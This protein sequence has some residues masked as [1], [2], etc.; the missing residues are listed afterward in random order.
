M[1]LRDAHHAYRDL[2]GR[3]GRCRVRV[4]GPTPASGGLPVVLVTALAEHAGPSLTNTIEQLAAEVLSRYLPERDG[5]EPPFLLV[6]HEPER[7][8]ARPARWHDPS[9]AEPFDLVRFAH[10]RPKPTWRSPRRG[11]VQQ[12]G[13]PEWRRVERGEVERL[14]G[15]PLPEPACS[16][17]RAPGA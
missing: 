12:F 14:L 1:L 7:Q 2:F 3:Q 5:A 13:E 16:C 17:E 10:H 9:F 15:E 11:L 4:Y 6:E 8:P